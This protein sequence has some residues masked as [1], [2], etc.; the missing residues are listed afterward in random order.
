MKRKTDVQIAKELSKIPLSIPKNKNEERIKS[1]TIFLLKD[2]FSDIWENEDVQDAFQSYI[3][4]TIIKEVKKAEQNIFDDVD[5]CIEGNTFHFDEY[6]LKKEEH[7]GKR[8]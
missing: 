1:E 7:L 3:A 8:K 6:K 5:S 2:M 4:N